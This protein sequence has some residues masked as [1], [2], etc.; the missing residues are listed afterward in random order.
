MSR[1]ATPANVNGSVAVT[2]KSSPDKARVKAKDA[3][4]PRHTG[5]HQLRP[6]AQHEG[7]HVAW[8]AAESH[9]HTDL[10]RALSRGVSEDAIDAHG[11][12]D[13]RENAE[14]ADECSGQASIGGIQIDAPIQSCHV[15]NRKIGV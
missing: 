1:K 13:E 8:L 9:A 15:E 7:K 12:E 2:P 6:L 14:P 10:V 5:E 11:R 3:A 4:R